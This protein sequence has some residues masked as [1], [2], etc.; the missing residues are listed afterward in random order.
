[1]TGGLNLN[2]LCKFSLAMNFA[3]LL[4]GTWNQP[5]LRSLQP[6]A[7]CVVDWIAMYSGKVA[8]ECGGGYLVFSLTQYKG[9]NHAA[10][11]WS[12]E[13]KL[14]NQV[15]TPPAK[16]VYRICGPAGISCWPRPWNLESFGR[17][18][19]RIL[20]RPSRATHWGG[21]GRSIQQQVKGIWH[22]SRYRIWMD[23]G[24]LL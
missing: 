15:S 7:S 23:D 2:I 10:R 17:A 18:I 24:W 19:L 6:A 11:T 12:W 4:V 13:M 14:R 22:F 3:G 9:L 16:P 20:C 5:M 1:M 8:S 21:S